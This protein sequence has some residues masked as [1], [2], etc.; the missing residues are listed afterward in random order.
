M[1]KLIYGILAFTLFLVVALIVYGAYLNYSGENK[2]THMM[3]DHRLLLSGARAEV[4]NVQPVVHLDIVTLST[5]T[6]ADAVSLIDG[7]V[8]ELFVNVNDAVIAGQ[9]VARVVNPDYSLQVKE[10]ESTLLE[11]EAKYQQAVSDSE[12]YQRL[13]EKEAT[14]KEKM[15][16]ART[17]LAAAR[18]NLE[19]LQAKRDRLLLQESYQTILAPVSGKV[20]INYLAVGTHVKAGGAIMLIGNNEELLFSES[21]AGEM[22]KCFDV[23]QEVSIEFHLEDLQKAYDTSFG[24]GNKGENQE[25]KARVV[26]MDPPLTEEASLRRVVFQVDNHSGILDMKSYRDVDISADISHRCLAVPRSA[27]SNATSDEPYVFVLTGDDTLEQ[28]S[29]EVGILNEKWAGIEAGL[30]EGEVVVTSTK[31]GLTPDLKV[32]V[33]VK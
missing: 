4:R 8:L 5:S 33:D 3:E 18:A 21:M 6:R 16:V 15:E 13:W 32:R 30:T 1:K 7:Q 9:P 17:N 10:L 19:T 20:L 29:V 12:R 11:A 27:V 24:V 26:S 14:S 28:R 22:A 25:I 23:G 2:I 31:Q